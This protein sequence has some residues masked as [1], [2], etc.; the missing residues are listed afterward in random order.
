MS[1]IFIIATVS[2]LQLQISFKEKLVS[3]LER[4]SASF[5]SVLVMFQVDSQKYLSSPHPSLEEEQSRTI[6]KRIRT[7]KPS[8]LSHLFSKAEQD[9]LGIIPGLLF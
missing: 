8:H 5:I 1:L 7:T 4:V 9:H 2:V 6:R 3:V